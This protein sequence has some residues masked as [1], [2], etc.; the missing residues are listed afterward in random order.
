MYVPLLRLWVGRV[1]WGPLSAVSV[2]VC[3]YSGMLVLSQRARAGLQYWL[4]RRVLQA[5]ATATWVVEAQQ[6]QRPAWMLLEAEPVQQLA[7]CTMVLGH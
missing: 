6:Q 7:N 3:V 1:Q 4:Q 2:C 5:I